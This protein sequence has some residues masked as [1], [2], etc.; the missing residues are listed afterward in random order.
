MFGSQ[1]EQ[2]LSLLERKTLL[3][4]SLIEALI[5]KIQTLDP[6]LQYASKTLSLLFLVTLCWS[7]FLYCFTPGLGKLSP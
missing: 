7:S 3:Q 1:P 2:N 5:D 4:I 6:W